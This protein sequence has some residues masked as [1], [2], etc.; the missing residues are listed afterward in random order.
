MTYILII[1]SPTKCS[2]LIFMI[3]L[4]SRLIRYDTCLYLNCNHHKPN[5]MLSSRVA[6]SVLDWVASIIHTTIIVTWICHV[7]KLG[8][9]FNKLP[10][11]LRAWGRTIDISVVTVMFGLYCDYHHAQNHHFAVELCQKFSATYGSIT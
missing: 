3:K 11:A 2:R 6:I 4:Y 5:D 10:R 8:S 1:I 7:L 9:V